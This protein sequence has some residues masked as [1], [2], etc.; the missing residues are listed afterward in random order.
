MAIGLIFEV[1]T[2]TEELYEKIKEQLH[3][4]NAPAEGQLYH[5]AGKGANGWTVIEVWESQEAAR[6]FFDEKLGE[7]LREAGVQA[8]PKFFQVHNV[9]KP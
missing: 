9:I 7:R 8:Q 3:P 4:G 2:V 6:K 1:P 5:A